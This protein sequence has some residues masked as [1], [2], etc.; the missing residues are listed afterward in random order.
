[1]FK[2]ILVAF[3]GSKQSQEALKH[4]LWIAKKTGARTTVLHVVEEVLPFHEE[5]G[6]SFIVQKELEAMAELELKKAKFIARKMKI[7]A[8]FEALHGHPAEKAI[9]R[10]RKGRFDLL[11]VGAKGKSAAERMF[12]GSVSESVLSHAH[13][14]VLVV[15]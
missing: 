14:A 12:L 9:E 10:A 2:N 5:T 15:K 6:R 1:M 7:K 13:C 3:D 8:E 4:A 11:V